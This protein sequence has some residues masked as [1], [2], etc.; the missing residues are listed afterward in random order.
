MVGVDETLGG[1]F[2]L[3]EPPR[4]DLALEQLVELGGRATGLT[5]ESAT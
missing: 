4:L 3:V 5:A 2:S 1:G